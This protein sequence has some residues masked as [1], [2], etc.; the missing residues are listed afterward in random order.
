[1]NPNREI[2]YFYTLLNENEIFY[3]INFSAFSCFP[4]RVIASQ[5][6]YRILNF[7]YASG[8][9]AIPINFI[10]LVLRVH[11]S[12]ISAWLNYARVTVMSSSRHWIFFF[13][14]SFSSFSL[15]CI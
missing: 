7:R 5:E 2:N 10:P 4:A 6:E 12:V 11:I 9:I 3:C 14:L 8:G 13:Y 1:M 15:D